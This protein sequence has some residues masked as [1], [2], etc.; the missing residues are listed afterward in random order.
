MAETP[1]VVTARSA[2]PRERRNRGGR[3]HAVKHAARHAS[4]RSILLAWL[5]YR[6][7]RCAARLRR[8]AFLGRVACHRFAL[9]GLV[10]RLCRV[11]RRVR[12]LERGLPHPE[13]VLGRVARRSRCLEGGPRG[14]APRQQRERRENRGEFRPARL[15]CR[16]SGDRRGTCRSGPAP[17]RR[18]HGRRRSGRATHRFWSTR[19]SAP[20]ACRARS[21]GSRGVTRQALPG[22]CLLAAD[23]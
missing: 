11:A 16:S 10:A 13:R 8:C 19:T 12:S 5:R 20:D 15:P 17:T 4:G 21:H 23:G 1:S 14:R 22:E 18:R 2:S 7:P 3:L 6:A 9:L